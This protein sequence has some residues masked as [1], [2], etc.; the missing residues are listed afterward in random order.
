MREAPAAA[1]ARMSSSLRKAL[2]CVIA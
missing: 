1:R 2:P